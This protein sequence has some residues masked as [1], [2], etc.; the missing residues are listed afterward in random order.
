VVDVDL[1]PQ[2]DTPVA[3][4]PVMDSEPTNAELKLK[5]DA[6][7]AKKKLIEEIK[8]F[9]TEDPQGDDTEEVE[10]PRVQKFTVLNPVK[11]GGHVKYSVTGVDDEGEFQDVRRFREFHAL[12]QVL[13]IRWPGCYVPSIPEK[14]I[15]GQNNE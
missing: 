3:T 14:K 13:R 9:K 10:D 15:V 12:G 4:I 6:D 11:I 5:E 7:L 1:S 2:K 8:Q